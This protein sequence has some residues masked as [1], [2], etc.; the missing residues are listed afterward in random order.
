M[1][2]GLALA[3][4]H[5]PGDAQGARFGEHLEQVRLAKSVGFASV[6]A[7]QHYLAQPFT[8]FQPVPTLARVAA[9]AEGMTLGTGVILLPL[10]HPLGVAE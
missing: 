6:W 3:V 4:Q 9:E 5:R 8:Y 1:K 7:S 2:F 10:H